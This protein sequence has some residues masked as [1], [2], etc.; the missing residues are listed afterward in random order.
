VYGKWK[1]FI[2][3]VLEMGGSQEEKNKVTLRVSI[4]LRRLAMKLLRR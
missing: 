4:N 1:T 3:G 2:D